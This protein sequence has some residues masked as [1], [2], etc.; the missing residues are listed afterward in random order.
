MEAGVGVS[1]PIEGNESVRPGTLPG[2][3]VL[4][5]WHVGPYDTLTR[6]HQRLEAWM[7]QQG[8][9]SAGASWELYWTDPGMQPDS[10][11]WRTQI[12]MPVR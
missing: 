8:L 2:G 9:E 7:R 5:A 3:R 11:K 1:R 12:L 10:S 6:T 4:S